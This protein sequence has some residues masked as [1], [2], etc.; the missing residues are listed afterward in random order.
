MHQQHSSNVFTY[1]ER[2]AQ[3]QSCTVWDLRE[4]YQIIKSGRPNDKG[5]TPHGIRPYW[6]LCDELIKQ[7]GVILK[8]K[9]IVEQPS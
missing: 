1:K 4:L 7:D 3:F 6:A 5:D 2:Y 9:R 8:A